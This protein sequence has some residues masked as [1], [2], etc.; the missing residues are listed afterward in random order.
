MG[1]CIALSAVVFAL[2]AAA[3][4]VQAASVESIANYTG[5]DRQQMLEKGARAEGEVLLYA[6]GAQIDPLIERFKQ[7]YPFINAK[8]FRGGTPEITK[9]ALEEYKAGLY[10]VDGYEL[11]SG[12]LIP[13]RDLGY[14]QPF[15]SPELAAYPPNAI[16]D[17]KHWV[18]VRESYNGMAY[19]SQAIAPDLAPKKWQ[20]LLNPGLKG[21][22]AMTKS[23]SLSTEWTGN[24]L[25]TYGED[26]LKKLA[27][28]NLVLYSLD[29]RAFVNLVA[30]GEIG[31]SANTANSHVSAIRDRKQP[32]VWIDP[33]PVPVTDT[34]TALA[35][36]APHPHAM[37]LLI[38]FLISEEGQGMYKHIGYSSA[39]K[40]LEEGD[41]PKE[42]VY[43]SRRPTLFE[44][45]EKWSVLFDRLFVK[46]I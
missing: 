28:Q 14:L 11:V 40:G 16:E 6:T 29:G 45:F 10:A 19:N 15:S 20:D 12:G 21:K 30:T 41:T 25:L 38:D 9:R 8:L 43:F 31:L 42:K 35:A 17:K 44:D 36:K 4:A 37:M 27:Q 13:L 5:T 26:F 39:R 22:I 32:V 46:R 33:G 1:R 18:A 3:S 34:V 24:L 2:A 7:K 23:A